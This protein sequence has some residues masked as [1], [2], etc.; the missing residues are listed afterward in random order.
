MWSHPAPPSLLLLLLFS[1][2]LADGILLAED[3]EFANC[4]GGP[5]SGL[6]DHAEDG[7]EDEEEDEDAY[8]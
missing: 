2:K 8:W 6:L 3:D 4:A 5:L 7:K 1:I